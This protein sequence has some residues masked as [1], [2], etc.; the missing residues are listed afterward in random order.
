MRKIFLLVFLFYFNI[1]SAQENKAEGGEGDVPDYYELAYSAIKVMLEGSEPLNF[2]KAVLL[3]ENAYFENRLD[4]EKI[5]KRIHFLAEVCRQFKEANTLSDYTSKDKETVSLRGAVFKVIT[6][7]IS[8]ILPNG[9]T[10]YHLPF[11]YDFDD[12]FGDA[13]WSQTFITK[14]LAT[15]K[16]NCHSLPYLYKILCEELGTTAH[17]ALAPNHVYIKHRSE[18]TGW[19]NTELTSASFPIDAWLMASGYISLTAIQ[20]RIFMDTLSAKQSIALCLADLAQ[21]YNRKYPNNDGIFVLKCADLALAYYPH[22]I[23]A[24]LLKSD[25]YRKQYQK[26]QTQR[27]EKTAEGEKLLAQM[28]KTVKHI[29]QLGYRRMPREM[30]INWLLELKTEIAKYQNPKLIDR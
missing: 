8:S 30:Y 13:E 18:K 15:E 26:L 1:L 2:K 23:N 9:E 12:F 10:V 14:L 16:G 21:G 20:N 29:H 4:L 22:C 7:T 27:N 11:Q 6:D 5:D 24:M 25:I 19:Y 28:T 3:S 17:L